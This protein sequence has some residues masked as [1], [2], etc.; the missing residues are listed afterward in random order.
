MQEQSIIDKL[1]SRVSQVIQK[2]QELKQE[3]EMLRSQ[4]SSKDETIEKLREELAMK[5]L[6]IEEIVSKIETILG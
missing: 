6:E 3:S 2:H 4:M 1:S 5:D